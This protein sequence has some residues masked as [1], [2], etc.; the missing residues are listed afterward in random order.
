MQLFVCILLQGSNPKFK[1]F[2][3]VPRDPTRVDCMQ[4]K[5]EIKR[6]KYPLGERRE[7]ETKGGEKKQGQVGRLDRLVDISLHGELR[8]L[9]YNSFL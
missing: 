2:E 9:C 5:Q 1:I 3:V 7:L 4:T 6:K 8:F